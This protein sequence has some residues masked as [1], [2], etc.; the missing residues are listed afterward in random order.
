MKYLKILL[1]PTV[2][3]IAL[4]FAGSVYLTRKIES[5]HQQIKDKFGVSLEIRQV[6][7]HFFPKFG[8]HLSEISVAENLVGFDHL[9]IESADLA[10]PLSYLWSETA[11]L[12]PTLSLHG[13]RAKTRASEKLPFLKITM[14]EGTVTL[15]DKSQ[16]SVDGEINLSESLVGKVVIK[17][18]M[19]KNV[20][21]GTLEIESSSL[22]AI[23]LP[24]FPADLAAVAVKSS[25]FWKTQ[26]GHT[27]FTIS[28]AEIKNSKM[29]IQANGLLTFYG[30]EE[31][32]GKI[33][34]RIQNMT[35]EEGKK[36]IPYKVLEPTL[37]DFLRLGLLSGTIKQADSD[38][39][40]TFYKTTKHLSKFT[41]QS[42]IDFE[43]LTLKFH[44]EWE[45]IEGIRGTVLITES[46]LHTQG[47]FAKNAN[48]ELKNGSVVVDFDKPSV[49][50]IAEALTS[51]Q[52]AEDY[53][54]HSTLKK[55]LESVFEKIHLKG[56][57][58]YALNLF[59]PLN[60]DDS[61]LN[62]T[63]YLQNNELI[64]NKTFAIEK[65][66]GEVEIS[67]KNLRSGPIRGQIF[68]QEF[69]ASVSVPKLSQATEI[70]VQSELKLEAAALVS[71]LP[72]L[73]ILNLAG[74]TKAKTLFKYY[75]AQQKSELQVD[76]NLANLRYR[77]PLLGE[78]IAVS[79]G[80]LHEKITFAPDLTIKGKVGEL[81]TDLKIGKTWE[82]HIGKSQG[83]R[84]LRKGTLSLDTPYAKAKLKIKSKP[85]DVYR[86]ESV[87]ADFKHLQLDTENF[88]DL[89][90]SDPADQ[91]PLVQIIDNTP[92]LKFSCQN[93]EINKAVYKP[94]NFQVD[95]SSQGELT[96]TS[97]HIHEDG[98]FTATV[99]G[100]RFKVI[101]K[102]VSFQMK[103]NFDFIDFGGF[104]HKFHVGQEIHGFKGPSF[105]DLS[106]TSTG[107]TCQQSSV[108]GKLSADLQDGKIAGNHFLK[109]FL[110]ILTLNFRN[111]LSDSSQIY[112]FKGFF[113]LEN[114]VL[115]TQK[116][117]ANLASFLMEY[118]GTIN[119]NQE[120]YDGDIV[121]YLN[122]NK[123]VVG[124]L[125]FLVNP[126]LSAA[127][128]YYSSETKTDKSFLNSLSKVKYKVSGPWAEPKLEKKI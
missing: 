62:S 94:L 85:T 80:F 98:L 108:S 6:S 44:P 117:F 78:K 82:G 29:A 69:T 19:D 43:D 77:I 125:A 86:I 26:E 113:D 70:T 74:N 116:T 76:A 11:D 52:A 126:L 97:T 30:N 118:E 105:F 59:I 42:L 2:L 5:V 102:A 45:Q 119:L 110:D 101:E 71:A 28:Q 50:V 35:I 64:L 10:L 31:L 109:R 34:T 93:C 95:R 24:W 33:H 8:L 123:F 25:M 22:W 104:L 89:E 115:K 128:M 32:L 20:K 58:R 55:D 65:L 72:Y 84:P 21:S 61:I 4:F 83:H 38:F 100:G 54:R 16:I 107:L 66:S 124:A 103:G 9:N 41:T 91:S 121:L 87:M 46:G 99:E 106:G 63:L 27:V 56:A 57:I 49:E 60:E 96:L 111:S 1:I 68:K 73:K 17:S 51:G 127:Y 75:T 114:N 7:V 120:S 112:Q 23:A 40:F 67:Q 18:V 12:F 15:N 92:I 13:L 36:W 90:F 14:P 48:F 53:L 81:F 39:E 122:S 37:A 3:T 79:A 88:V 47:L